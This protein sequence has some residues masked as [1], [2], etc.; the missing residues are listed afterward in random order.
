L[1]PADD[2]VEEW[3][4]IDWDDVTGR[5]IPSPVLDVAE[6]ARV[7]HAIDFFGLN[8]DPEVR[9]Q[10]SRAYEDAARLAVERRWDDLRQRAMRHR[11]HSL[12]ARIV[13]QRVAPE[14]LP[15]AVDEMK[16]LVDSLWIDLRML[17]NEIHSLRARGKTP[18]P[19]D[20]RQLNALCWA[21]VVVRSDPPAGD[22]QTADEYFGELLKQEP[23]DIRT[24]IVTL[25]RDLQ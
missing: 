3:L 4:T 9:T 16:E 19:V 18:S 15:S 10:R 22:T 7:Q 6:H 12:A 23:A 17:L 5:L 8:L 13:L 14:R 21:L 25:F 11:P 24:E 20:E 2:P 1:D